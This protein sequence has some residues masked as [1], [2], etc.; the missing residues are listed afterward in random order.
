MILFSLIKIYL[1][2]YMTNILEQFD[3][4]VK[5]I[6]PMQPSIAYEN[7]KLISLYIYFKSYQILHDY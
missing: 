7:M 2:L 1:R 4:I 3:T 5:E 6:L